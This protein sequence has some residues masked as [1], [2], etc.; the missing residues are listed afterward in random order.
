MIFEVGRVCVKIAGRET[1]KQCAVIEVLNDNFV[2]VGGPE[3]RKRKCN[4]AHLGPLEDIVDVSKDI[5][6]QLI[7]K[8]NIIVRKKVKEEKEKPKQEKKARAK[9]SEKKDS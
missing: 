5:N 3:V 1:G 4:V 2:L 8:Y 7:E 6:Q 9:K